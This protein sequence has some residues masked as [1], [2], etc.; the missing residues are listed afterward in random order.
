MSSTSISMSERKP[1]LPRITLQAVHADG[2]R[3]RWTLSERIV[4]ENLQSEHYVAQ[5]IDRLR[6]ATADAEVLESQPAGLDADW[7]SD[8]PRSPGVPLSSPVDNAARELGRSSGQPE[9]VE[10]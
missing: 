9:R 4:A 10:A 5:L 2:E 3:R 6:W 8:D 7:H 1:Q